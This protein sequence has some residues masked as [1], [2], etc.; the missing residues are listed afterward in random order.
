MQNKKLQVWLPLLFS[1]TAIAGIFL[2]YKIRDTMPG[3]K[4]FQFEK[5][6]AN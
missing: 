4:F 1:I 3:K 2:G 5:K 6:T